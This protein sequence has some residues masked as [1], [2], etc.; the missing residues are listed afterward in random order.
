MG[1]KLLWRIIA[2]KS[3]WAQTTLWR[4]YFKGTR[5]RCLDGP[6]P[7][8]T[9]PFVSLYSKAAQLIRS[10]AF[11]IPGNGKKINIWSDCIM[12]RDPIGNC[13]NVIALRDWLK[14]SRKNNLWDISLWNGCHWAGWNLSNLPANLHQES[15]HLHDLLNG[16][17]PTYIRRNDKQG[18]GALSTGY[19]IA[20][21]YAHL[22]AI[23]NVPP[24][25][26]P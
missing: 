4:K 12:D 13:P 2:P 17:A 21:G 7:Q 22:A 15:I 6:L 18:W 23:P 10:K 14:A 1:A 16:I 19:S 3:G 26:A 5:M 11:W 24:D 8:G 9:S 25:L 20:Q